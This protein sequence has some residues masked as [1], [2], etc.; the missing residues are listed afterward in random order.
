MAARRMALAVRL[1][2]TMP[3]VHRWGHRT[4]RA[5][6]PT[7]ITPM[8]RPPDR[9]TERVI[10][11]TTTMP[12]VRRLGRP[13]GRAIR[14]T[15]ITRTDL[16]REDQLQW[17]TRPIITTQTVRRRGL[18]P[19]WAT[20]PTTM[21]RMAHRPVRPPE[22]A[23]NSGL[24]VVPS[25]GV[26]TRSV[27]RWGHRATPLRLRGSLR[28]TPLREQ[29]KG[30]DC[31]EWRLRQVTRTQKKSYLEPRARVSSAKVGCLARRGWQV[32]RASAAGT[33]P[34]VLAGRASPC[35]RQQPKSSAE[36]RFTRG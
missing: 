31:S 18:P 15:T 11:R 3:M 23:G 12:T 21:V 6:R 27:A 25:G 28:R 36:A 32:K 35:H 14:R 22:R 9:P 13:T 17:A 19:E 8:V 4:G 7:T 2:T 30:Y 20:R 34:P 26:T 5:T 1:I 24:N 16:L 29:L 10:R 33:A